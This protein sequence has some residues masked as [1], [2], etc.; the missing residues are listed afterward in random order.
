MFVPLWLIFLTTGAIMAVLA[1]IWSI[2]TRQFEDQDRAR[3]LPLAGLT[4][5]ELAEQPP[6]RRG[7]SFYALLSI[8]AVSLFVLVLTTGVVV[9]LL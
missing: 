1:L 7:A 5:E 8:A 6:I 9:G 3:W 2:R 4:S